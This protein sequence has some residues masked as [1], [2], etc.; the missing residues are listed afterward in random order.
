[1]P[2]LYHADRIYARDV[3]DTQEDWKDEVRST[4][5]WVDRMI[6]FAAA[7]HLVLLPVATLT[8]FDGYWWQTISPIIVGIILI[9]MIVLVRKLRK[10]RGW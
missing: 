10:A 8:V 1:M 6:L 3:T 5:R 2:P 7:I 4:E 9:G